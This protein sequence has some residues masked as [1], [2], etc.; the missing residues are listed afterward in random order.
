MM[1]AA[2]NRLHVE[3]FF[4]SVCVCVC[5]CVFVCG[6]VR[7]RETLCVCVCVRVCVFFSFFFLF[8]VFFFPLLQVQGFVLFAWED[9]KKK[10]ILMDFFPPSQC[11]I[12]TRAGKTTT[13]SHSRS[14]NYN[15]LNDILRKLVTKCECE[16]DL[17]DRAI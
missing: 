10:S 4:G 3:N 8:L 14:T 2:C 9:V 11:W 1:P 5:A 6:C 7:E 12:K 13:H 16:L 15:V 17:T